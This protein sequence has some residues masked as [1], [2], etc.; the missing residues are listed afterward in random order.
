MS[1]AEFLNR[2]CQVSGCGILLD[3]HNLY[4]NSRNHGI[5]MEAFLR[6]IDL[7]HVVEIHVAGGDE[8][9]G[10]YTVSHLGPVQRLFTTTSISGAQWLLCTAV[11]SSVLFAEEARKAIARHRLASATKTHTLLTKTL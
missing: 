11:A 10:F 9:L 4:V 6:D 7:R 5:S 2:L 3:L 8:L 1:E